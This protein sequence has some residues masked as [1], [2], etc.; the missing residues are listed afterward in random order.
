MNVSLL[1]ESKFFSEERK[2]KFVPRNTR[3]ISSSV[4]M[5][6]AAAAAA[7]LAEEPS[8]REEVEPNG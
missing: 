1:K 3:R 8:I 6:A 4:L 2:G 5:A 7:H